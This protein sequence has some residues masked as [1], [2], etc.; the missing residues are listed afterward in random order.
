MNGQFQNPF[1]SIESAHDF[2]RL[3]HEEVL[4]AKQEIDTDLQREL[5]LPTSRRRDALQVASYGLEKLE[6]HVIKSRR[7]LNDLRSVRRLLF[8]ER[9]N[10]RQIRGVVADPGQMKMDNQLIW[11]QRSHT[12]AEVR[13]A[14]LPM[15][16]IF[17][18]HP[19]SRR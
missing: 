16:A 13:P 7:I 18:P 15:A 19:L 14:S 4:A 3:L 11:V 8:S 12:T 10:T 2:L 17:H 9:T 6:A 1:E 5:A